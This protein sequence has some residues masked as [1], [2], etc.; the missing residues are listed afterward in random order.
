M[1]DAAGGL[2]GPRCGA[3]PG[4]VARPREGFVGAI[5]RPHR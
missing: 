2:G 4:P 3:M 1:I 5:S